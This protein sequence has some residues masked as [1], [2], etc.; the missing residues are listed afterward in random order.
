MISC[1]WNKVSD[2]GV[3]K[4]HPDENWLIQLYNRMSFLTC[5][6]SFFA[7]LIFQYLSASPLHVIITAVVLAMH[8]CIILLHHFKKYRAARY[9]VSIG[10]PIWV[11]IT[12]LLGGGFF[13]QGAGIICCGTVT[14]ITFQRNTKERNSLIAINI[15]LFISALL[16]VSTFGPM[17]QDMEIP[18]DETIVFIGSVGWTLVA[19][20]AFDRE[21]AK[22]GR[23]LRDNHDKLIK[24]TEELERFTY[25]A[26]HDL[27][28]P[29]RTIISFIGL[30]ERDIKKGQTE[31][32]LEK[33]QFI[34][35]GAS[36]MN[37]LVQDILELSRFRNTDKSERSPI[38]LNLVLKK[39]QLNLTEDIR[40]KN[41]IVIACNKLPHFMGNELELLM[42][43]QNFIQNGIKYNKSQQAKIFIHAETTDKS[44]NISFQD[45]GI[46]IEEKYHEQIFQ[47]FKRLHNSDEYKGTGLGLGLCHKII[48]SYEGTIRVKSA[49]DK[50]T[51]FTISFPLEHLCKKEKTTTADQEVEA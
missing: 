4:N 27:K 8:A 26:S 20:L 50:G 46:G 25:I 43:F 44:W 30:I 13:C 28:S 18:H 3:S 49:L 36:Q 39:A 34:K 7:I 31:D 33:L 14:Y 51:T 5:I 38:D 41:A 29:L 21:R 22:L 9:L 17:Y 42:L 1:L 6:F 23:K 15:L 11:T 37:F 10:N 19:I 45:N 2:I 32:L 35:T 16:W 12:Y 47:F 48:T 40:E 24:T